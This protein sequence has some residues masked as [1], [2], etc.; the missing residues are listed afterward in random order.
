MS[1]CGGFLVVPVGLENSVC[2]LNHGW[3]LRDID[4]LPVLVKGGP[5]EVGRANLAFMAVAD[6]LGMIESVLASVAGE[7][8]RGQMQG[9]TR[10]L[11]PPFFFFDLSGLHAVGLALDDDPDID[12]SRVGRLQGPENRAVGQVIHANA[13]RMA[14]QIND[15]ED[16]CSACVRFTVEHE[17]LLCAPPA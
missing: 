5:V 16:G 9:S 11:Y 6:I 3:I 10:R 13:H 15:L 12:A 8:V 14:G 2:R 17:N 4:I 1:K 7:S